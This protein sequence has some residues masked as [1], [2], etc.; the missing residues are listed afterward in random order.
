[1]SAFNWALFA[2]TA[3]QDRWLAAKLKYLDQG[4]FRLETPVGARD[5]HVEDGIVAEIA[6]ASGNA[7]VTLTFSPAVWE[8]LAE[9]PPRPGFE[10]ATMAQRNGFV[11]AGD[12]AR[13]V[14]PFHPAIERIY[15]LVGEAM[16]GPIAA[17]ASSPEPFRETDDPVG[18][19]RWINVG[20]TD[21]RVYYETAGTGSVPLLLQHTAGAD[22]RQY[23]H[24]LADPMLQRDFTMI[25]YD[26][27]YHGRSLPP[28]GTAW[29]EDIYAVTQKQLMDYVVAIAD[30]LKLDRPIFMGCSVGGQLALD[31]AAFHPERFRAFI[32]LNGW[33]DMRF[34]EEF[35]NDRFRDPRNSNN[36]FASGCYGATTPLG[37][38][39]NRQES[40]WIY[41]SNFPGVYAGDNDYFMHEHDFRRDGALLNTDKADVYLLTGSYDPS[42]AR[43]ECGPQEVARRFPG[44]K[45]RVMEGLSHFAPSDDPVGFSEEIRPV[46]QEIAAKG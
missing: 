39:A 36:L 18:R 2:G 45:Y 33:H 9:N 34:A 16:R 29:W 32:S 11:M 1:M 41:R 28:T 13:F 30:A 19:Y 25:A 24:L 20:G 46:L 27:P 3:R 37:P 21:F 15:L 43:P 23:R 14:A 10:S 4:I 5:L 40:Y 6:E 22:G 42:L 44:V 26:L 8:G 31:L 17:K 38:E 7:D 12:L 35:S